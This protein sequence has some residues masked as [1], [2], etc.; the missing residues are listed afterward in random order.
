VFAAG[1]YANKAYFGGQGLIPDGDSGFLLVNE[2]C[3]VSNGA[4]VEG[5]YLLFVLT[6][7]G[8][9]NADITGPWGTATMTKFG[10]GTFKYVST[11]YN[12][13]NLP[14]NVSATYD[15]KAKNAQL[16]ISHGCRPK[17]KGAWCS[18]GFWRNAADQAW[19]VVGV[20]R[21]AYFND[22]VYSQYYG[23]MF[24]ENPTLYTVLT[25]SGGT[26]KGA[27]VAGTDPRTTTTGPALNAFNAVGAYLT[28]RIPGYGYDP[29]FLSDEQCPLTNGGLFKN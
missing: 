11:W 19:V 29:G 7:T 16:V 3:N 27:G 9:N 10:A 6:A 21:E 26:Y 5:P 20:S 22:T 4:E 18:P 8:S 2:V 13:S 25:T 12:P 14:G 28:D 15:G 17:G 23:A 24:A 1:P